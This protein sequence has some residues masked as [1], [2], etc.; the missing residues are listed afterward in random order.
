MNRLSPP[1]APTPPLKETSPCPAWKAQSRDLSQL[2]ESLA[3]SAV[4]E[5]HSWAGTAK[6]SVRL[7]PQ[8]PRRLQPGRTHLCRCPCA[9]TSCRPASG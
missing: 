1:G 3:G 7:T 5:P 9:H 6:H 4:T 8:V 2:H